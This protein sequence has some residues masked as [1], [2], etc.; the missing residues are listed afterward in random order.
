MVYDA[1]PSVYVMFIDDG[2]LDQRPMVEGPSE[3]MFPLEGELFPV[4]ASYV[5]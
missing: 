5:C 2:G 1:R 3:E 4:N